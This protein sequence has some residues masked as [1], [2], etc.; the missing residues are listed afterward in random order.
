MGKES[1]TGSRFVGAGA[2]A[3]FDSKRRGPKLRPPTGNAKE[4]N[5]NQE[6][7]EEKSSKRILHSMG[8]CAIVKPAQQKYQPGVRRREPEKC[9]AL[10]FGNSAVWKRR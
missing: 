10:S 4:T 2:P 7:R 1:G 6:R 5:F 8:S 9:E 3:R